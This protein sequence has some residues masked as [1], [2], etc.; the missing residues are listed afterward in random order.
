VD[1]AV[2]F[3]ETSVGDMMY[4]CT[5]EE[6][7]L[8]ASCAAAIQP[9]AHLEKEWDA[10]KFQKKMLEYM[11][12]AAKGI[13]F[14]RSPWEECVETFCTKFFESY[15]RAL[16]DRYAYV[17]KIDFSATLGAAIKYHFPKEVMAT[18]PSEEEFARRVYTNSVAAM[19]NCRWYS[20]GSQIVKT[21]VPGKTSQKNVWAAVDS[22]RENL[23]KTGHGAD[24]ESFIGSW[25]Q[26][27]IEK[28]SPMSMSARSA[29]GPDSLP[30][31][32]AIKLFDELV[33]QG[34]GMPYHLELTQGKA[35]PGW[36]PIA[37]AVEQSYGATPAG[38][39]GAFGSAMAMA[40]GG[41]L[42]AITG[43]ARASPY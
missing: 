14:G 21:V 18:I 40:M 12:K 3:V 1:Q 41:A 25:V 8:Y 24:S 13:N 4:Q 27:T 34:G 43:V 29:Q 37:S 15:W 17:E 2:I 31:A 19:D 10:D 38:G 11:N 7:M 36:P 22:A 39:G 42:P 33:Q 30:K 26:A 35:P 5:P 23:V 20:W 28:L 32:V 9:V 6:Q 16:G